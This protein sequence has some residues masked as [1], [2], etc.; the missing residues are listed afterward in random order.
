MVYYSGQ[1]A[2]VPFSWFV[3]K[4]DNS[5]THMYVTVTARQH[6][7]VS[8]PSLRK[9]RGTKLVSSAASWDVSSQLCTTEWHCASSSCLKWGQRHN[10][11]LNWTMK[12]YSLGSW[13]V[14]LEVFTCVYAC[15]CVCARTSMGCGSLRWSLRSI[16]ICG[17][18][19]GTSYGLDRMHALRPSTPAWRR[20]KSSCTH[21]HI[22]T[23]THKWRV[24]MDCRISR[25]TNPLG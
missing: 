12:L 21:A 4:L 2:S 6:S 1:S 25:F 11:L 24:K 14:R 22:R 15:V 20:T 10:F 23:H 7:F 19:N 9:R 5:S 8:S 3:S 18:Q 17:I 13:C 16:R